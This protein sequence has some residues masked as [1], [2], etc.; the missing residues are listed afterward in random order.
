MRIVLLL[1]LTLLLASCSESVF[2]ESTDGTTISVRVGE[3]FVVEL[4]SNPSTG[5]TW[6]IEEQAGLTLRDETWI[7]DSDLTGSPGISRFEFVGDSAGTTELAMLYTR[8]WIDDDD[9]F[10]RHFGVTVQIT[11]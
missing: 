2:D 5:Y 9:E 10:D 1:V 3:T 8:V 4:E 11:E 6:V 7:G